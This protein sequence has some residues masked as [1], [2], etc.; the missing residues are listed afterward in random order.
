MTL[1]IE[2][3]HAPRFV[4]RFLRRPAGAIVAILLSLGGIGAQA[5]EQPGAKPTT[6]PAVQT[7]P[8]GETALVQTALADG[9]LHI[10]A[11]RSTVIKTRVPFKNVS[12]AQPD[13]ADVNL[14]GPQDMLLTAKK[15]G[16]TQLVIWDDDG[17]SQV[18]EVEVGFDLQALQ[19]QV[20]VIFPGSRIDV[21][22]LNG[23]IAL[24]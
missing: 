16:S 7:R 14:V 4:R 22:S 1:A 20:K 2:P 10:L 13:V 18:I 6:A 12:I 24:R 5:Q 19:D 17:R 23:T 21:T 3:H 11:N 15:P 8:A 9:V